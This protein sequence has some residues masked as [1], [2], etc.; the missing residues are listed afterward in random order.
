MKK[1]VIKKVSNFS[2]INDLLKKCDEMDTWI[3][4]VEKGNI[5]VEKAIH[6][7]SLEKR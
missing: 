4:E 3:K 7:S 6:K 5:V 2:E 1:E